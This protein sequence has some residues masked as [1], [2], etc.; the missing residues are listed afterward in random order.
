M[1]KICLNQSLISI[2][3]FSHHFHSKCT[4]FWPT[5]LFWGRKNTEEGF[6]PPC[7]PPTYASGGVNTRM[8]HRVNSLPL[9]ERVEEKWREWK[10]REEKWR[11]EK[12]RVEKRKEKRNRN[13]HKKDKRA[14]SVNNK[15]CTIPGFHR[16]TDEICARLWCYLAYGGNYLPTFR[17]NLSVPS[18]RTKENL[19]FLTLKY[20]TDRLSRNVGK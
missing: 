5:N 16:E 1:G 14:E 17:D 2:H 4:H 20:G 7:P 8:L 12:K 10:K 18:S 13:R 9:S 6:A 19:D 11:E 15:T 3:P